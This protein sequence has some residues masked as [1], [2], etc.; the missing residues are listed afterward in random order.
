MTTLT[1]KGL[2]KRDG[3]NDDVLTE[4]DSKKIYKFSIYLR[5]SKIK[6]NK[7][8]INIDIG[9]M[10]G[11]HLTCFYIQDKNS[12]SLMSYGGPPVIISLHHLSK[13]F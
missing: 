8:F 11:S 10:G 12:S 4:S 13:A 2:M 7:S 9:N 6:T 3:L 1:F 5:D